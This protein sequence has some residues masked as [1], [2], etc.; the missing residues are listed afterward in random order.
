[1]RH[2]HLFSVW[3]YVKLA[4]ENSDRKIQTT[5][6]RF[7]NCFEEKK[8]LKGKK[9]NTCQWMDP[10]TVFCLGFVCFFQFCVCLVFLWF[11]RMFPWR[12]TPTRLSYVTMVPENDRLQKCEDIC[13]M[14][15]A[16][17]FCSFHLLKN[18]KRSLGGLSSICLFVFFLCVCVCA[19]LVSSG[20][21]SPNSFSF[22]PFYT[23]VFVLLM[24]VIL[25]SVTL[26]V[27]KKAPLESRWRMM[28]A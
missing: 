25:D 13:N 8:R 12:R 22:P 11:M 17:Y 28:D 6:E 20:F 10:S 26:Y 1:M 4:D 23:I 27:V 3:L 14:E 15:S 24:F 19:V 5:R 2:K 18:Y 21:F 16:L 9:I 7:K